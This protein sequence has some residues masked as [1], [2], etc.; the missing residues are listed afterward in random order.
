MPARRMRGG[1]P[2]PTRVPAA[3]CVPTP[4]CVPA[5]RAV[6]IS[7][8]RRRPGPHP[9]RPSAAHAPTAMGAPV[10]HQGIVMEVRRRHRAGLGRGGQRAVDH[11]R[12]G[13]DIQEQDLRASAAGIAGGQDY[14]EVAV[15]LR[16]A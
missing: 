12:R 16:H 4:A 7:R 13:T 11:R 10:P 2:A 5:R 6:R 9:T 1:V 15:G 8:R 3:R 14:F